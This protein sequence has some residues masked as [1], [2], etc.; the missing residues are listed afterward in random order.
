M[1]DA[2][3]RQ[4][5]KDGV[6]C[7]H[8]KLARFRLRALSCAPMV[9]ILPRLPP[10]PANWASYRHDA[11]SLATCA[12][13]AI[14]SELSPLNFRCRDLVF[15]SPGRRFGKS[16]TNTAW[17]ITFLINCMS[18]S[19]NASRA[20]PCKSKPEQQAD[21]SASAILMAAKL[22]VLTRYHECLSPTGMRSDSDSRELCKPRNRPLSSGN[23]NIMIQ[24]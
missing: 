13:L 14:R 4:R 1:K 20:R 16:H 18:R 15:R 17:Q 22:G 3:D 9:I 12:S 23:K 2:A 6:F 21:R 24:F 7:N 10:I 5:A 11:A 19:R 8:E